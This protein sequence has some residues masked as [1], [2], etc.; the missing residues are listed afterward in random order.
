MLWNIETKN[1]RPLH[2]EELTKWEKSEYLF[3][4][5]V[6]NKAMDESS[7]GRTQLERRNGGAE[8][9]SSAEGGGGVR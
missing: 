7:T 5:E 1:K 3:S 9:P 8:S 4:A 6:L 2:S